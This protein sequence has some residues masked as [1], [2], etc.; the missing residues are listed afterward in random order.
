MGR[1]NEKSTNTNEKEVDLSWN[2]AN[3]LTLDK[4]EVFKFICS[5]T[6]SPL[7]GRLYCKY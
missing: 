3:A 6:R 4:I 7:Q 5:N 2:T 1:I